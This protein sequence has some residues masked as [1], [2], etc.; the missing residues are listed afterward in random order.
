MSTPRRPSSRRPSARATAANGGTAAGT[1]DAAIEDVE[2][3][4]A[5][6]PTEDRRTAA[7]IRAARAE[8]RRVR[9]EEPAQRSVLTERTGRMRAFYEDTRAEIKKVTWPDRETTRNLT[10]V[11]IGISVVLGILLGGIDFVLF[12][13][14]EALP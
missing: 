2:A 14:F 5:A 9:I 7:Q 12:Q 13:I 1:L 6:P 8:E 4:G 11:V 10:I 3:E